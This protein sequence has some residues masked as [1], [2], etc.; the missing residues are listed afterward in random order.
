M[1]HKVKYRGKYVLDGRTIYGDALSVKHN[2][3]IKFGDINYY[4]RIKED[5]GA[6]FL[7]KD[8]NG[9]E[10][11]EGDILIADDGTEL[12]AGFCTSDINSLMLKEVANDES[13]D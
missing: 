12:T 13:T 10:V 5:S 8:K 7:G 6:L 2:Y 3:L 4:Y 11:Y 1:D 9:C